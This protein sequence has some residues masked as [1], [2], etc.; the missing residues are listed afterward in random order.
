VTAAGQTDPT[1]SIIIATYNARDQLAG[2]LDSIA[3]HPP[4][5][6][7]EVLVVDDASHDGSAEMVRGRFPWVRLLVNEH[8]VNYSASN[9][10]ALSVAAGCYIH[11]LNNDTVVLPGA[12]DA[13]MAFLQATPRAGAVGSKL[14]HPDGTVQA[15]VK[16]LPG[17]MAALFGSRSIISKLL[18]NNRFTRRHLLHLS[19]DMTRPFRA[20]FVSGASCM[21]RREVVQ[22]IGGLDERFFYHVDADYC[23]RIWDAGWE[24]YYLPTA[25]VV[26]LEHQGGSMSSRRRRFQGIVEFHRGSYLYFRKHDLPSPWHPMHGLAL[27]GLSARFAVALLL[28]L[29][30]EVVALAGVDPTRPR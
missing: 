22:R 18:P 27:V 20:G 9:N 30:R 7:F 28:Q 11:L 4:G 13:L 17:P 29:G 2:C 23:R 3:A 26:H 14:V 6:P 19:Y 15:S 21:I 8:N 16:S 5:A 25:A 24:V 1:L 10:R 12:L